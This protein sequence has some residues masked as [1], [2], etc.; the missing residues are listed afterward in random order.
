M[1]I[2]NLLQSSNLMADASLSFLDNCV[3]GIVP[4]ESVIQKNLDE[5]LMLV[6]ALN[7]HIGYYNAATIA[8]KAHKEGITLKQAALESGLLSAEQYDLWVIP[9]NMI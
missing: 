9:A 5:S 1:M 3:A 4:N 8:Q 6:T 2:Y 7:P